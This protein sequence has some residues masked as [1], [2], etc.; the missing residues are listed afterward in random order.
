[1]VA[2]CWP[3]IQFFKIHTDGSQ[4]CQFQTV[5]WMGEKLPA[6]LLNPLHIKRRSCTVILQDD[7]SLPLT[8]VTYS[9]TK[10]LE[11]LKVMCSIDGCLS[12]PNLAN[13]HHLA[14]KKTVYTVRQTQG[15]VLTSFSWTTLHDTI[16]CYCSLV[17]G[18]K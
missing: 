14:L 2:Y 6:V 7:F 9:T 17:P 13:K 16:P 12:W 10:I 4:G 8:F 18:L 1:M 15:I 11:F 5:G 3:H